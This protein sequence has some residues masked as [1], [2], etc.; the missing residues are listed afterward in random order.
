MGEQAGAELKG[1]LA[2]MQIASTVLRHQL[3]VSKLP[4]WSYPP[5]ETP[6]SLLG[7]L[8]ERAKEGNYGLGLDLPHFQATYADLGQTPGFEQPTYGRPVKHHNISL[9][10]FPDVQDVPNWRAGV[11]PPTNPDPAKEA[12][13]FKSTYMNHGNGFESKSKGLPLKHHHH[14][15]GYNMIDKSHGEPQK[16]DVLTT[17]KP[18]GVGDPVNPD[19]AKEGRFFASTYADL[20]NWHPKTSTQRPCVTETAKTDPGKEKPASN[21]ATG[22]STY[23]DAS[24]WHRKMKKKNS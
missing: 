21:Y 1:D 12:R 7:Q 17:F 15:I 4:G 14:D 3:S 23:A 22:T 13:F 2:K 20:G 16:W 6:V 8:P 5:P 19:P 9:P 11:G 10:V 24:N 18:P